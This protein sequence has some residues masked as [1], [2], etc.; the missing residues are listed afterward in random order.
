MSLLPTPRMHFS[1]HTAF[2][3]SPFSDFRHRWNNVSYSSQQAENLK[4]IG[5]VFSE[6]SPILLT[7]LTLETFASTH[8]FSHFCSSYLFFMLGTE[9]RMTGCECLAAG[10][11]KPWQGKRCY[12]TCHPQDRPVNT[13][14][15]CSTVPLQWHKHAATLLSSEENS[16][17]FKLNILPDKAQTLITYHL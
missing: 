10:R 12:S 6:S 4:T 13:A 8:E 7:F 15:L 14:G 16:C 3:A 11:D 2:L 5:D 9:G 17:S 1:C